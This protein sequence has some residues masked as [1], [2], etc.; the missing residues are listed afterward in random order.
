MNVIYL[1]GSRPC[2][3]WAPA[4]CPAWPRLTG[5]D[6]AGRLKRDCAWSLADARRHC[7]GKPAPKT[8][9]GGIAYVD[10]PLAHTMAHPMGTVS[11]FR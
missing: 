4:P 1:D 10:D 6:A 9:R 7:E 5:L 2:A 11:L 8:L 3:T